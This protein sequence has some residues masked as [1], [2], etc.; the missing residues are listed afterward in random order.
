MRLELATR[1]PISGTWALSSRHIIAFVLLLYRLQHG[2]FFVSPQL[3]SPTQTCPQHCGC[4]AIWDV[5]CMI[6]FVASHTPLI[7]PSHAE[8]SPAASERPPKISL[9]F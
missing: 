1:L 6:E 7:C 5:T 2:H 9:G 8:S 3:L 4:S